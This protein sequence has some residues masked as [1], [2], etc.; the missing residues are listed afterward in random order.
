MRE[1][2]FRRVPPKSTGR[3]TFGRAFA[4]RLA[5]E[6]P[7]RGLYP[8]DVLATVTAFTARSVAEAI[9]DFVLP[10]MAVDEILVSGGGARNPFLLHMLREYL[11][12]VTIRTI[13]EVGIDPDAKEAM[14]FAVLANEAVHGLPGNCPGA[15]GAER[16]TVLGKICLP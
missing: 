3:E 8:E 6:A 5:E 12:W 10:R 13:D 15:T 14:A 16:P 1:A 4:K 7:R 11:P 2:Y 9:N